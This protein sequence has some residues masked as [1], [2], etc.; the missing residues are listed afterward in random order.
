MENLKNNFLNKAKFIHGDKWDYSKVIYVNRHKKISIICPIHGEFQQKPSNHLKSDFPCPKCVHLNCIPNQNKH[1]HKKRIKQ[2]PDETVSG[3]G[4]W[5]RYCPQCNKKILHKYKHNRNISI[6][7]N[8][9]CSSCSSKKKVS[10]PIKRK[11]QSKSIITFLNNKVKGVF[12]TEYMDGK[13]Y[14]NNCGYWSRK[15]SKCGYETEY[16]R[17]DNAISAEKRHSNCGNC[18]PLCR[19]RINKSSKIFKNVTGVFFNSSIKQW[20]RNCPKCNNEITYA[21]KNWAVVA[22]KNKAVCYKCYSTNYTSKPEQEFL[23]FFKITERQKQIG[24]YMVDGFKNNI[25]YE[26]LGDFWHGNPRLYDMNKINNASKKTFKELYD[27]TLHRFKDLQSS[28]YNLKYIWESDWEQFKKDKLLDN[29]KFRIFN[30]VDL[31]S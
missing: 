15:C 25:I 30:G 24:K 14:L 6:K 7:R 27:E 26:F 1:H 31:I 10:T 2:F 17:I 22:E 28:G 19:H 8:Q 18:S 13:V 23:D 16:S 12:I 29:T 21:S 11:N 9:L 3:K 5:I 20:Y 4:M